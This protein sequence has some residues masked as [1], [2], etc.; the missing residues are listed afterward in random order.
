[1]NQNELGIR[2]ELVCVFGE[3]YCRWVVGANRRRSKMVCG[4][5]NISSL[6]LAQVPA[7]PPVLE[8]FA[9][10]LEGIA[11]KIDAVQ[12]GAILMV[13][14]LLAEAHGAFR[15]KH[16]EGGFT[17]WAKT[18]LKISTSGAYRLLAVHKQFGNL[19]QNWE[20]FAAALAP[21]AIKM[22]AAPSVPDEVRK[23]V[24]ERVVAG[25]K[26]T[27]DMVAG[28]IEQAKPKAA[29]SAA[30]AVTG[31]SGGNGTGDDIEEAPG[32]TERRAL[33][34]ETFGETDSGGNGA[35]HGDA[36]DRADDAAH[37]DD[38]EHSGDGH[39][40]HVEHGDDANDDAPP[41]CW[42]TTLLHAN[43]HLPNALEILIE[44]EPV[45][46][47]LKALPEA[48]RAELF[49]CLVLDQISPG[50]P[51]AATATNKKLADNLTGTLHWAF[52]D[53][54]NRAQ[55]AFTI[56]ARKLEANKRDPKEL[57]MAWGK[58]LRAKR[59]SVDAN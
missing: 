6:A 23:E 10:R 46:R 59:L 49:D 7:N 18:R 25:E 12:S 16:D 48:K 34:A 58:L 57:I 33:H 20:G 31:Q 51:V 2:A 45:E 28:L 43:A 19:S 15:Y 24:T 40:D 11:Q 53:P 30:A 56:M 3:P 42:V 37:G 38:A 5:S 29:E 47:I 13:A 50:A 32:V 54:A 35:E 41:V 17:G 44:R 27:C 55:Q 14:K 39:G 26:L 52:A 4:M 9:E 22:L 8:S 21:S 1:M 36:G